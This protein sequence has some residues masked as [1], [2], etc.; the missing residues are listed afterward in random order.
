MSVAAVYLVIFLVAGFL[1]YV[2]MFG[3]SS[4]GVIG[5]LH[6]QLT[7]CYCLRP[8]LR[9]CCGPR[10]TRFWRQVEHTC[11][12]RPNP[13]LQLF[14]LAL[15]AGGFTLY[16][17]HSLPLIGGANQRLAYWHRY[18]SY[19]TM[20]G[21]VLIFVA[22]SFADPGVVTAASLH[23]FSRVPYDNVLYEPRMCRTCNIPRPARS[24]HCVICNRCVSRFDHHCPWL[25]SC[26]GERN[27]RYFLL[28]LAY[29]SYLCFYAAYQHVMMVMH[30]AIDV[31][32]L[33]EA[34]YLDEAGQPQTI[35]YSQVL[36][37]PTLPLSYSP[38][39]LLSHYL[40]LLLSSYSTLLLST[41]LR[42]NHLL[43]SYLQG[44]QYLFVHH[45]IIMAIGIFTA[46][47]GIAL[48][49]F[50][51][52]HLYLVWCG[53]TT[54]ESFKWADLKDELTAREHAKVAERELQASRQQAASGTTQKKSGRVEVV[55]PQ[56]IY[57]NGFWRNL[58][59]V[60]YPLSSR[61]A[62]GF[63][64]ALQAG[65]VMRKFPQ[66]PANAGGDA[67]SGGGAAEDTPV[68]DEEGDD[69]SDE[70]LSSIDSDDANNLPA[71]AG[72][73]HAD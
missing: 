47:I 13:L 18:T 17:L 68:D 69:D 27:Y 25:N 57:D 3:A 14:Y 59:E 55:V 12:W 2:C 73:L 45:N 50:L 63:A 58:W 65:G 39:L 43:L 42:Y 32:R 71:V 6:D 19:A 67:A 41:L 56:N 30:L 8:L 26:V 28:F 23:R 4:S 51:A 61:P 48:F 49:G 33:P 44:F 37:T 10:C 31:H 70:E 16:A 64:Q 36:K 34:Y 53:T 46:V 15:M 21:G 7:G 62:K 72:K 20:V 1:L 9:L 24:K 11:C 35:S 52:Y 40:T 29:H 38:T 54:N 66:R 60:L 5:T 22:A